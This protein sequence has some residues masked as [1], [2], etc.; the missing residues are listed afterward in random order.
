MAVTPTAGLARFARGTLED[1]PYCSTRYGLP[2]VVVVVVVVSVLL[3]IV[4]CWLGPVVAAVLRRPLPA[5]HGYQWVVKVV[6]GVAANLQGGPLV[7]RILLYF[8][9]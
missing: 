6:P 4:P 1:A 5:F 9:N 2:P 8:S 7:P 3:C